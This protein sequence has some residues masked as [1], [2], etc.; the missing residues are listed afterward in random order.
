MIAIFCL[1][2]LF[3]RKF[4]YLPENVFITCIYKISCSD[5]SKT[6]VGQT[7]RMLFFRCEEHKKNI[8]L[9][10]PLNP[11]NLIIVLMFF[12]KI[13]AKIILK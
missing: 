3:E 8:N 1:K 12:C 7:G 4:K 2:G 10:E 5:C 11:T 6:Y 13:V 9:N